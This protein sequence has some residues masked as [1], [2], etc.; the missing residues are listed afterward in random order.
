MGSDWGGGLAD[1]MRRIAALRQVEM[2]LGWDR[3]TQ[4]PPKGAAQR[5][6]QAAAV[7]AAM[8]A[9]R[10]DP[11]IADWIAAAGPQGGGRRGQ[12]RRGGAAARA[13]R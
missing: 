10:S 6:E 9:H 1:H 7:A 8:H 3:E 5:A 13:G 11:R 12:S 4:M 2:L